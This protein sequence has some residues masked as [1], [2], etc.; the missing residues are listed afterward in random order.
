MLFQVELA[1]PHADILCLVCLVLVLQHI[2]GIFAL[3][4]RCLL[5]SSPT[6]LPAHFSPPS[7]LPFHNGQ[8]ARICSPVPFSEYDLYVS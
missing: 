7:R 8:L 1:G 6:P 5:L 4:S 2:S 3:P